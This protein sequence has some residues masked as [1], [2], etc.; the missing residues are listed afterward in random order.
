[1]DD[2]SLLNLLRIQIA[3]SLSVVPS[4][5][6]F[7]VRLPYNDYMGDS[8]EMLVLA[9]PEQIILEDLGHT[10]GLLFSLAQHGEGAPG[11]QLIKNLTEA[12]GITMDYDRG[13]LFQRLSLE[14]YPPHILDF[15]KVLISAQTVIPELQRRK[16]VGRGRGRLGTR[17]ARDIKQLHM[18]TYVQRQAKV[19]GKHEMWVVDYKYIHGRGKD[20]VDVLVVTAD[21]GGQE[22]RQKAEHVLTLA[23]DISA[24]ENKG[25]LRIVYDMDGNGSRPAAERAAALIADY[26]G[27]IGYKA[28]NYANLE[29]KVELATVTIQELSPMAYEERK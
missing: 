13:V 29:Q 14:E 22:P 12:Y 2:V 15:T 27:R 9:T 18:P 28:Y 3:D 21:L 24:T 8:I 19:M 5:G 4:S 17:L 7:K 16:R 1:M 25:Q 23:T 11:Y 10:A 6:G 20:A 26:A